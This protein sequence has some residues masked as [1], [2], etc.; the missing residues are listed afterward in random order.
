[1]TKKQGYKLETWKKTNW[2]GTKREQNITVERL[3]MRDEKGHFKKVITKIQEKSYGTGYYKVGISNGKIVSRQ[4]IASKNVQ[5]YSDRK[6]AT[7]DKDVYR[8]AYV[9]N[10]IPF[11]GTVYYGFRITA[12][13]RHKDLLLQSKQKLKNRLIQFIEKCLGYSE[14]EFWFNYYWG[15]GTITS[16]TVFKNENGR[17]YLQWEKRHGTI[18]K[19]E[20]HRL[21]EIL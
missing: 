4:K 2:K 7:T 14:D 6:K 9:L 8:I 15:E 13:S 11:Q 16:D 17:F 20:P 1:M 19:E 10:D 5:W 18:I 12:F 3:V 21:S